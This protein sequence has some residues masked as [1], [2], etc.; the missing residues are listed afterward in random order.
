[1]GIYIYMSIYMYMGIY[2]YMYQYMLS[3]GDQNSM[4]FYSSGVICLLV[5]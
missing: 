5:P 4:P 1:M 3:F 2:M